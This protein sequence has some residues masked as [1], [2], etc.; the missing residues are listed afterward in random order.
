M[1]LFV[2]HLHSTR[3]VRGW[4][5]I[6][7]VVPL[8]YILLTS[9]SVKNLLAFI[10]V[11]HILSHNL[12][13]F[14]SLASIYYFYLPLLLAHWQLTSVEG[15]SPTWIAFLPPPSRPIAINIS[16][17]LRHSLLPLS[18]YAFESLYQSSIISTD[19][20]SQYWLQNVI[21]WADFKILTSAWFPHSEI[22][23]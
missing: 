6:V 20:G 23:I 22:I 2:A 5:S 3:V 4:T 1:H 13:S 16:P 12:V 15:Y 14:P 19:L 8:F 11:P 7:T 17:P 10:S 18:T 9:S 21:P